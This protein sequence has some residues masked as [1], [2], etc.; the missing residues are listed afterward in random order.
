MQKILPN[1][2]KQTYSLKT[3]FKNMSGGKDKLGI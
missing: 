1:V 2:S 3:V